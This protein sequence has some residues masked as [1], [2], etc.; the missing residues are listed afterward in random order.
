[1]RVYEASIKYHL[2][3]SLPAARALSTPALVAEY[4]CGAFDES[5]VQESVWVIAV[6]R[7]NRPIARSMVSLGTGTCCLASPSDCFR[8]LILQ[9]AT[10]FI[11][12]HNHPSGDP[13]PSAADMQLTRMMREASSL[14]QIT[15]LDHVI[16]GESSDDPLGIGFYS[17]RNSGL[18]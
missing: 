3:S 1:M 6:N 12:V 8:F 5:P 17:F 14:M 11:M 10:G 2:V 7:R 18:L 4:M 16:I 13:S 15:L 9:A